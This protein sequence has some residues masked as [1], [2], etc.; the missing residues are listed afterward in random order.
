MI[1][2]IFT[3]IILVISSNL[4]GQKSYYEWAPIGAEWYYNLNDESGNPLYSFNRHFV[5]KDSLIEDK[6]CRVILHR[7]GNEIY[8]QDE[9]EI[10]Y[11]FK[12]KFNLIYDFAV[13][14]NDTVSFSFK[15]YTIN[16]L[17]FDTTLNVKCKVVNIDTLYINDKPLRKIYTT[18]LKID[19]MDH[20]VWPSSYDYMEGVGYENSRMMTISIPS[21]GFMSNLRCYND[22]SINFKGE[23][24]N[25][26]DL[27]CDFSS[28]TGINFKQEFKQIDTYPNPVK[29]ILNISI[30]NFNPTLKYQLRLLSSNGTVLLLKN[31][32][33][34]HS[35]L[36][37]NKF[38]HGFFLL[39]INVENNQTFKK[40]IIVL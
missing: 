40:K 14:V 22:N 11:Y 2:L 17:D 8:T 12:N 3:I 4:I 6:N 29:D 23:W 28:E 37:L 27:P 30:Q 25:Q 34:E 20:L 16:S 10:Y 15:S 1:K 24:F 13:K 31:I 7:F 32:T 38:S 9:G 39:T 18:I 35:M 36:Q 33:S 26:F 21:L 5:E 19:G